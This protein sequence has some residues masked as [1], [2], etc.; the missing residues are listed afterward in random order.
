MK[1]FEPFEALNFTLP[2]GSELPIIRFAY[3]ARTNRQSG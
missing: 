2:K 3:K 1:D